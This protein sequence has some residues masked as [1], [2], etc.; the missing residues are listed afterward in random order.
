MEPTPSC[1][2][3]SS[4]NQDMKMCTMPPMMTCPPGYT[5]VNGM[6]QPD[7]APSAAPA[8]AP[9]AAEPVAPAAGMEQP[10]PSGYEYRDSMCYPLAN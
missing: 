1:P 9:A 10:C 4:F 8:A 5:L 6:C 2:E 3:G 7:S